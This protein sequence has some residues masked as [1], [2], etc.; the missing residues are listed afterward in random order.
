MD[1]AHKLDAVTAADGTDKLHGH[2]TI[3]VT[4]DCPMG[5]RRGRDGARW[6][7][8]VTFGWCG[9]LIVTA[10]KRPLVEDDAT[11]L[12]PS[13][14]KTDILA[15]EFEARYQA[16]KAAMGPAASKPSPAV[17]NI[18]FKT[19]IGL[20]A[21]EMLLNCVWTA[22]E[23]AVR[24]LGPVIL[25]QFLIWLQDYN[26]GNTNEQWQGWMLAV[27]LGSTGLAMAILHH[28]LFWAGMHTG[29][30]MRQQC[31]A[32][33]HNKVLRLNSAAIAHVSSGHVVNLVSN[34][35]RRFDDAGPFWVFLWAGPLEL[36][37]VLLMV[38]LE[39]GIFPA[40]AGVAATLVLIP[41][42]AALVRPVGSIRQN[43]ASKTD[44][45][46]R[47]ASEAIQGSLAM[48]M[49][50]WEKPIADTLCSIRDAEASFIVQMARIKAVNNA[51]Y[52]CITPVVAFCTFAVYRALNGT[53]NVP[54]VFY[55]LSLLALPKLYMV[56]FFI[57]AVQSFTEL[58]VSVRR[59]DRFL[60]REEPPAVQRL[61]ANC[62]TEQS[63]QPFPKAALE[64][65]AEQQR[66]LGSQTGPGT[67]PRVALRGADYDWS[68][69]MGHAPVL[70]SGHAAHA[71]PLVAAVVP[72]SA[73]HAVRH[74][75]DQ[76][77]GS[78]ELSGP[79]LSGL[80]LEVRPGELLGITG[81]VGSG[82]SSML[83]A[84]LG[85]LLPIATAQDQE[86]SSAKGPLLIGSVA[87]SSQIPW[88]A[89]GSIRD[90]ITF[91]SAWDQSWYNE[92]IQACAL[93]QDFRD[94]SAGD[95]TE[96]GERGINLSGGQKARVALARCCYSRAAIQL[97]DDPLSAVDPRVGRIL[98]D[99]A[100][101]AVMKSSTR[102]LITHQRQFLP[103]CNRVLVLR[104]GK[105]EALG[106]WE[107]LA[108]RGLPELSGGTPVT[109]AADNELGD[110]TVDDAVSNMQE[111]YQESSSTQSLKH[112][113]SSW[114]IEGQL[115]EQLAVKLKGSTLGS[116]PD[117]TLPSSA[118][119]CTQDI[120]EK[121]DEEALAPGLHEA[122]DPPPPQ[123]QTD[124]TTS[125]PPLC[126]P[127][128]ALAHNESIPTS[129][130]TSSRTFAFFRSSKPNAAN[131]RMD[132]DEP[133]LGSEGQQ[134]SRA[135]SRGRITGRGKSFGTGLLRLISIKDNA[136]GNTVGTV[137][138]S[139][140]EGDEAAADAADKGQ[141]VQL[142]GRE[143]GTIKLGVYLSYAQ[144]IGV[145]I[146]V[147]VWVLLFTGQAVYLASDWWLALWSQ[148]SPDDQIRAKWLWVYGLL[149]GLV[150]T[151]SFVR[152]GIFFEFT[153]MAATNIH[154]LVATRVLKA[155][156]SFFHRNPTGRILNRFSKDLA[157][158]DDL[159]PITLY[160]ALQTGFQVLQVFVMVAIAVPVILPIFLPL[161][162]AFYYLRVR[163]VRT[164]REVKRWE[165]VS[166][167]PVFAAFSASLKG[168][169]TIRAFGCRA[170]FQNDFMSLL[171]SN[172]EWYYAFIST[173][174]WIGFRLDV[175]SATTLLCTALLAVAIQ[176][177]VS[178]YLLGL[179]LSY[180]LQL[181]GY[182]QWFVRQ[183]AE[184]ENHMTALERVLEYSRLEQEPPDVAQGGG[185]PPA[186]WP[187]SGALRF[188]NVTA[189]Y[190]PGLPPVLRN[191]SFQLQGGQSCG[192]VGRTGSG[193]SSLMLTLFRLIDVTSGAI[194]LDGIDVSSIGLDA[195]RSQLAIIPQ[196]PTLFSG[197]IRSNLDP[198][199][200]LQDADLWE[201]LS[202]VKMQKVIAGLGGLQARMQEAGDNLS[203]GQR[204][205]FC[206]ARAL[207]Q[208][209]RV[210]ALDEATANVDRTTDALIQQ[211]LR[212]FAH[213]NP[214]CGRVLLVI[215]HRIDTIMDCDNLLVLS[216]G[217]LVEQGSPS[218]L[219]NHQGSMFA[220]MVAMAQAANGTAVH[221]PNKGDRG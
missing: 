71:G 115:D 114:Q 213:H 203:V 8:L 5:R 48:K 187:S 58:C 120:S 168:L 141:L 137:V 39:L 197:T 146:T 121:T 61:P 216:S 116:Q 34:D 171:Q 31:V 111:T 142:E 200:K 173:A 9:G 179:A 195:L 149:T 37:M 74:K 178:P 118:P 13:S 44:E 65:D 94:L 130:L 169:P 59:I 1:Q 183:T 136:S 41:V 124:I 66:D 198:W 35:V 133:D 45:R 86:P 215:A 151:V 158:V 84:L 47:L 4:K 97:L 176:S 165:A 64:L 99:K 219:C 27:A 88:I 62:G 161:L 57:Q 160:D 217:Q 131:Q 32:A 186:G 181:T 26:D 167:S 202:A 79:T 38:A 194:Y 145:A 209:A 199:G 163:Y 21:P 112:E 91:G 51:L 25:R 16:V 60:G 100:I 129:F 85:E 68:Q 53:L 144:A 208:D 207:L 87:Y 70:G 105:I 6:W 205:L 148:S 69:P 80:R 126:T 63:E 192:L 127:S 159:L 139:D 89:S 125:A 201:V 134:L 11:Y 109:D 108:S 14:E 15:N 204:Q 164:S 42:Q 153:L 36:G 135:V 193:K 76:R 143:T 67:E 40:L 43:T 206:L 75:H 96:L 177:W 28:Q 50:S 184:V 33:I 77:S 101:S 185:A 147:I 220:G 3:S 152:A 72:P 104:A 90:N 49:L 52:F 221:H 81:E 212:E 218:Y 113:A 154:N 82:K 172:G 122:V 73:S 190:R 29:F 12:M 155:P 19:L 211:S 189:V 18:T 128:V 140:G 56:L 117:Q 78:L 22:L 123:L 10:N 30:S 175:I 93:G 46:V 119:S 83:A 174:R 92:V 138:E 23:I 188:D 24:L 196:D 107:E 106:T 17:L 7:E 214:K 102:L 55:A 98:F 156:L 210:L 150:V 180:V 103:R 170:R 54:S 191:I 110:E 157:Q 20:H 166:R 182:L 162:V 2:A 132:A 95:L